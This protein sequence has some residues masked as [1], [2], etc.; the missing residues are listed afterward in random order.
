[1]KRV[2]LL[3]LGLL[4]GAFALA[5]PASAHA[6]F[7]GSTPRD[8][9]RLAKAPTSVTI[10]FDDAVVPSFIHVTGPSGQ[11]VDTGAVTHPGGNDDFVSV[12]LKPRLPNGTYVAEYRIVADD[13]HPV[14]GEISFVVG[15]GPLTT[16]TAEDMSDSVVSAAL[17]VSRWISYAGF[18][19]LGGSW[20]LLTLWRS[21][22]DERPARRLVQVGWIAAL[23]G[24]V[25]E[26]LLQGAYVAG[27]GIGTVFHGSLLADTLKLEYGELHVA[28][29][30]LL[31]LLAVLPQRVFF[32]PVMAGIAYTFAAVGHPRTTDP[33]WLSIGFDMLHLLAIAA[34][35][36]GVVMILVGVLPRAADLGHILPVYSK[37]AFTAVVVIA[38]T[39]AYAAYR[40]VGSWR[41]LFDTEYGL[42]VSAKVLGFLG[43]LAVGN[44]ARTVIARRAFSATD[45]EQLRRCVLVETTVAA[46]V[47][48]LAAVLVSQPR[49]AETLALALGGV[50]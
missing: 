35:I 39:G 4:A 50:R 20:L 12:A 40:G 41:A 1:M 34:W 37:V 10:R 25:L 27:S 36:G 44:L 46:V 7:T 14:G 23:V 43:L 24:A 18:A 11:R 2:A 13:G 33:V 22:R 47:L 26:L 29:L 31:L 45:R 19:L 16:P 28:R 48:A 5:A 21:G 17:D 8:G 30:A 32:W 9:A 42:L 15:A 6:E 3:L 49:G 38:L